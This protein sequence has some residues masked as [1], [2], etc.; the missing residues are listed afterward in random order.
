MG[1]RF[2]DSGNKG[3]K[4]RMKLDEYEKS[5]ERNRN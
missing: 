3:K 2:E 4:R 5:E 1:Q